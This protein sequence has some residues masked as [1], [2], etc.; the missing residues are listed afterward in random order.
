MIYGLSDDIRS[1][2]ILGQIRLGKKTDKGWPE[3]VPYF[4]VNVEEEVFDRRGNTIRDS[5][6]QPLTRTNQYLQKIIDIYGEKP[7]YLEGWF[8]VNDTDAVCPQ[9]LK[10]H[11]GQ[12]LICKGD[13]RIAG[14]NQEYAH[15]LQGKTKA[16]LTPDNLL[17]DTPAPF[18]ANPKCAAR[19]CLFRQCKHF[20]SEENKAGICKPVMDL[21]VVLPRVCP[22]GCFKITTG[23]EISIQEVNATIKILQN[24][25]ASEGVETGIANA[26]L[27]IR[28][29]PVKLAKGTQYILKIE[30]MTDF[31]VRYKEE[32]INQNKEYLG[33]NPYSIGYDGPTV[34]D[35]DALPAPDVSVPEDELEKASLHEQAM[36]LVSHPEIEKLFTQW[37]ELSGK[38]VMPAKRKKMIEKYKD[39]EQIKII[40]QSEIDKLSKS[41]S[42]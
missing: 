26:P 40:I 11:A 19:K 20:A 42:E 28:R 1:L 37:E 35:V 8:P 29:Q 6:G 10:A 13:G 5:K 12:K 4:V 17:R 33:V 36:E 31:F 21:L 2:P 23:S 3:T 18:F 24:I 7:T 41:S 39:I 15:M 34:G 25:A 30:P 22:Y 32:I 16:D 9:Y 27:I 38:K 14:W